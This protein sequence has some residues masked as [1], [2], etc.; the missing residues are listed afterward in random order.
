MDKYKDKVV[1]IS[2]K[3]SRNAGSEDALEVKFDAGE[4]TLEVTC[5]INASAVQ[6]AAK[7]QKGQEIK[8]TGIGDPYGITG[9][10]FKDCQVAP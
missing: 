2:G 4:P 9:P 7:F 10:L 3:F 1:E 8:M 6:A 5:R